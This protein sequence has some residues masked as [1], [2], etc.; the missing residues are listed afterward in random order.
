MRL[1]PASSDGI[2][3][4]AVSED[5]FAH[6]TDSVYSL[7][8]RLQQTGESIY[9]AWPA[10]DS[11][12]RDE[13]RAFL[14]DNLTPELRQAGRLMTSGVLGVVLGDRRMHRI[15]GSTEQA[16]GYSRAL[17]TGELPTESEPAAWQGWLAVRLLFSRYAELTKV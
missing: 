3:L 14:Q 7:H 8:T 13:V 6:L 4:S 9:L 17:R 2:P 5:L 10:T 16:I 12:L 15:Y 11:A 1:C